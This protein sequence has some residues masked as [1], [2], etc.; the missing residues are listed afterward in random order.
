MAGPAGCCPGVKVAAKCEPEAPNATVAAIVFGF[1]DAHAPAMD[2]AL[3]HADLAPPRQRVFAR[4]LLPALVAHVLL[5]V[6]LASGVNWKRTPDLDRIVSVPGLNAPVA[7]APS[8]DT[9]TMGGPPAAESGGSRAPASRAAPDA[10]P[11]SRSAAPSPSSLLAPSVAAPAAPSPSTAR[12]TSPRANGAAVQPSFDCAK[13][14]STPE[15]IICADAELARLD[16]ELGRLHAR[17]KAA[18]PDAADFK[19]ENDAQW[20][21]REQTC[22][23]RSCLMEWYAQ[24][25]EQLEGRLARSRAS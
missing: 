25:R 6:A 7:E 24:R 16:R 10:R 13:A 21:L 15:R 5:G 1:D 11:P 14:R 3:A 12:E 22:R 19:R 2:P 20:K 8:P 18:A 17:A 9:A 23:D 4:G